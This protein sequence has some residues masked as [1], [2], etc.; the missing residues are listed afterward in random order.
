MAT[1]GTA[2]PAEKDL[3]SALVLGDQTK[4]HSLGIT[5]VG[6]TLEDVVKEVSAEHFKG[7]RFFTELLKRLDS[8]WGK[9]GLN[10]LSHGAAA[11][12]ARKLT[13]LVP[14]LDPSTR[15]V[16]NVFIGDMLAGL[17]KGVIA[18]SDPDRTKKID[19]LGAAVSRRFGNAFRDH[20]GVIHLAALAADGTPELDD[21]NRPVA[22]VHWQQ[23]VTGW[24]LAHPVAN[25]QQG[26][27]QN[28]NQPQQSA[29][30]PAQISYRMGEFSTLTAPGTEPHV[31][32]V[33]M[34]LQG[35]AQVKGKSFWARVRED[36]KMHR[37][38]VA[39]ARKDVGQER[40]KRLFIDLSEDFAA[41]GD[42]D[43]LAIICHD[44]YPRLKSAQRGGKHQYYEITDEDA[45]LLRAWF[46]GPGGAEL[47]MANKARETEHGAVETV[48]HALAHGGPA[49]WGA[50][51]LALGIPLVYFGIAFP[52]V[53]VYGAGVFGWWQNAHWNIGLTLAGAVLALLW[54]IPWYSVAGLMKVFGG[55]FHPHADEHG[56][57][58]L[59]NS[60]RNIT[61]F[62]FGLGITSM[63]IADTGIIWG[64][65]TFL[66][67]LVAIPVI[68]LAL[69]GYDRIGAR[70]GHSSKEIHHLLEKLSFNNIR[71]LAFVATALALIGIG[72]LAYVEYVSANTA[73]VVEVAE[74]EIVV[75]VPQGNGKAVKEEKRKV[76]YIPSPKGG[77]FRVE[78]ILGRVAAESAQVGKVCVSKGTDID[79]PGY[80][81]KESSDGCDKGKVGYAVRERAFAFI[82]DDAAVE[83][84]SL[85]ALYLATYREDAEIDQ[86]MEAT[87][88]P[89][90]ETQVSQ[91]PSQPKATVSVVAPAAASTQPKA[92]AKV[93]CS[94]LSPRARSKQPGC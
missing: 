21:R 81:E 88:A 61:A 10:A 69:I 56:T 53:G 76:K 93:D 52:I 46:D 8:K 37:V 25:R 94:R 9:H 80:V 63:L 71:T 42:L 26:G 85:E 91:P 83:Y 4:A 82:P 89:P 15:A 60:A 45:K 6:E 58:N 17:G 16:A 50:A 23:M 49:A 24:D 72:P 90:Q 66:I 44:V 40:D 51:A 48:K 65:N 84:E 47:G 28:Q 39:V 54:L 3:I 30:Q 92:K 87:L 70:W 79:L 43:A 31:C 38:L 32:P 74:K 34:Q 78:D 59:A 33:C 1:P 55:I 2:G 36:E 41:N 14:G 29:Q 5:V 18:A 35:S 75:S 67:R 73:F 7:V 64:F 86:V 68:A 11:A 22:C 62:L 19:A 27:R 13:Q 57:P 20:L 77:A 12:V